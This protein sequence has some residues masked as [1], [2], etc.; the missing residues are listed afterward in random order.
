MNLKQELKSLT[1]DKT[2]MIEQLASIKIALA[3]KSCS[4]DE[5]QLVITKQ[6]EKITSLENEI[7]NIK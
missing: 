6:E 5:R 4:L 7:E 2:K 3:G 1:I